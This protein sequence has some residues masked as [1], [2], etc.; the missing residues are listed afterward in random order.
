VKDG[1]PLIVILLFEGEA[2]PSQGNYRF[3]DGEKGVPLLLEG[4]AL[5][6]D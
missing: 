5:Q 3:G 4:I 1:F 6:G 2:R